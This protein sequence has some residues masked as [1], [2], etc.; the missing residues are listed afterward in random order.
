MIHINIYNRE[1]D[2]IF[3]NLCFIACLP[4]FMC[5]FYFSHFFFFGKIYTKFITF[6]LD[7]KVVYVLLP[8]KNVITYSFWC[9]L[10]AHVNNTRNTFIWRRWR[11]PHIWRK[12]TGVWYG[13]EGRKGLRKSYDDSWV[14][15]IQESML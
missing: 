6:L 13:K 7:E 10:K 5:M 4:F 8:K 3:E 12:E 15:H 9:K 14:I 2:I 1:Y 11:R